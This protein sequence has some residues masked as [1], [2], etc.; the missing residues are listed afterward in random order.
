MYYRPGDVILSTFVVIISFLFFIFLYVGVTGQVHIT[1]DKGYEQ[2]FRLAEDRI[3]E[4]IDE[5]RDLENTLEKISGDGKRKSTVVI[6]IL[7]FIFYVV[8]IWAFF[9]RDAIKGWIAKSH[10]KSKKRK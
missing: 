7:G 10:K 6:Y 4:L 9:G 5:R 2:K 1:I 3:D 8:N